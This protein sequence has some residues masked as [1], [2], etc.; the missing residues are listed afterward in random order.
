MLKNVSKVQLL[1]VAGLAGFM[2]IAFQVWAIT[3]EVVFSLWYDFPFLAILTIAIFE[4]MNRRRQPRL[5]EI[6]KIIAEYSFPVYLIHNMVI[7]VVKAPIGKTAMILPVK[8]A[9]TCA[10]S[11]MISLMLAWGISKI[12]KF[13]TFILYLRR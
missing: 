4:L 8:V 13:G 1:L 3:K 5:R 7:E 9:F 12:P 6:A 2:T 11:A 10:I